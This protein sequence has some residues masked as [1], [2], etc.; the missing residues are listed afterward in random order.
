LFQSRKII[1][2]NILHKS[3]I[4]TTEGIPSERA[5]KAKGRV[6]NQI[7]NFDKKGYDN[8]LNAPKGQ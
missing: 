5:A 8:Y 2:N 3:V 4:P 6:I 1:N 7:N